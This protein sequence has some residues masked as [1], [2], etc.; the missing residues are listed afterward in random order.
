M[1]NSTLELGQETRDLVIGEDGDLQLLS[2]NDT[3]A[4]NVR[5]LLLTWRGD[6]PLDLRHGTDYERILGGSQ[7][8]NEEIREVLRNA[9]FQ[10][11]GV[12]QI[13]GITA[14]R[15]GKTLE[16]SFDGILQDGTPF[17]EEVRSG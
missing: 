17:H 9:I 10:E 12:R 2:G 5:N 15:S 8:E 4:Q 3:T 14:N 13:D 6:W 16:I 11:D 1:D 7:V